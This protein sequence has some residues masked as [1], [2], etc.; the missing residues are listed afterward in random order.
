MNEHNTCAYCQGDAFSGAP[1]PEVLRRTGTKGFCMTA[2]ELLLIKRR[3]KRATA[4]M[5]D[6]LRDAPRAVWRRSRP[7][8]WREDAS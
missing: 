7:S 5:L 3:K 8:I 4:R 6:D 1:C 2:G